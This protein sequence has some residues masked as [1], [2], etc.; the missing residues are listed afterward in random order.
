MSRRCSG[1][2]ARRA[3]RAVPKR[4][5]RSGVEPALRSKAMTSEPLDE[6]QRY[7]ALLAVTVSDPQHLQALIDGLYDESWRV[8]KAAAER[9]SRLNRHPSVVERLVRVLADRGQT[10]AR[11]AA[12]EAL[13]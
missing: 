12:A 4:L 13:V 11:N 2:D 6:E 8:R 3:G 7:R 1:S 10:G 9:V 5:G